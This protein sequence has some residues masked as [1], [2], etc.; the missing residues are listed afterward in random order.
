MSY[1]LKH[2]SSKTIENG[3]GYHL[4]A[5]LTAD[6]VNFAVYSKN[7]AEAFLLLFDK[8]DEDPT[9]II[10]L[11]SRDKYVWHAHVKGIRAG[12]LYG[13]KMRGEYHPEWGLHFN[14]AKLLM[15]PYAKALTG[16]FGNTENLLLAYEPQPAGG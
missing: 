13:Y 14:D 3:K 4:G 15:D 10:Q 9:D 12:Q 5:S 6:G 2:N 11:P 1:E 7:A 8:P 16:K